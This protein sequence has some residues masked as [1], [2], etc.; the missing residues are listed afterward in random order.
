MGESDES[1]RARQAA[2]KLG[3]IVGSSYSLEADEPV[4]WAF[5]IDTGAYHTVLAGTATGPQRVLMRAD[6]EDA[7]SAMMYAK[8]LTHAELEAHSDYLQGSRGRNGSAIQS[9][10]PTQS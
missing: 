4:I 8:A 10:S 5:H 7:F 2:E 9:M 3:P 1:R 6:E